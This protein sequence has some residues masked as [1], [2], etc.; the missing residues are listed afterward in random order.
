MAKKFRLLLLDAN[1]VIKLFQ[2][3]LC[4]RLLDH[5]DVHL[6]R[7]IAAHEAHFFYDD[8]GDRH[9]FDLSTYEGSGA[10]TVFDVTLSQDAE[11]NKHFDA[12]YLERFDPGER[13]AL[14]HLVTSPE[15]YSICSAD[16]IV[17]KVLGFL[18]R[19]E[20]G[21]SLEEI[22]LRTGLGRQ[23]P[24]QFSKAFREK[25]TNEGFMDRQWK[26]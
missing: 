13:E 3:G 16:S 11:L 4:D 20:Q 21:I 17:F 7:T 2:M 15:Q 5:C 18:N 1:V 12:Q 25:Y 8:T 9:D 10:I 23:L 24:W 14:A 19:A 26:T 22:L 6:S